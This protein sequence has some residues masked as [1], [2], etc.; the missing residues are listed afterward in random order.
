MLLLTIIA[1]LI[2]V[3]IIL[4]R[5]R[6]KGATPPPPPVPQPAPQVDDTFIPG[7]HNDPYRESEKELWGDKLLVL[8][9]LDLPNVFFKVP[10]KDVVCIGR[11]S[12]QDIVISDDNQVSREHCKI[13]LRG[14]LMYLRRCEKKNGTYYEN[15]LVPEDHEIPIV[16]GGK[17]KMGQYQYCVELVDQ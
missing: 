14:G 2:A 5:T 1:A 11:L 3:I 17:I 16:S 15:V 7:S 4:R 10:I 8:R 9:N 6:R 13:S 12:T